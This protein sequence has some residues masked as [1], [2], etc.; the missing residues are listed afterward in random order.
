M[1][2]IVKK[3][4]VSSLIVYF[5]IFDHL[6][7]ISSKRNSERTVDGEN[8]QVITRVPKEITICYFLKYSSTHNL[9]SA[10]MILCFF[11]ECFNLL[12]SEKRVCF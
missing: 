9:D 3:K 1:V 5:G 6:V 7:C 4:K 11:I 8:E 2:K 12:V 10:C